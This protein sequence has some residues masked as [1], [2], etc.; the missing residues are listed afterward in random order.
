[1]MTA[2][3]PTPGTN[4]FEVLKRRRPVDLCFRLP[5][6]TAPGGTKAA[7]LALMVAG[8]TASAGAAYA[9]SSGGDPAADY[10]VLRKAA[11]PS[12]H[13]T[14][15]GRELAR[16]M[17][18]SF[19]IHASDSRRTRLKPGHGVWLIPGKSSV[20]LFVEQ[21]DGGVNGSC[22]RLGQALKGA[23]YVTDFRKGKSKSKSLRQFTGALPDDGS[24]VR[25]VGAQGRERK[26]E[27]KRNTYSTHLSRE[28][29]ASFKPRS[30][31]FEVGGQPYSIPLG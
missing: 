6:M 25:L 3:A 5:R 13:L 26:L 14:K 11:K 27:I 19:H 18:S 16:R 21:R 7:L 31:S 30:V 2:A 28:G 9:A 22:N 23:L 20:C 10:S 8:V 29:A 17:P 1:M 15:D 24:N 12:D 4:R